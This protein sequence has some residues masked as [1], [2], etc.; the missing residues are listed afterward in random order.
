MRQIEL[1]NGCRCS[2]PSV[3]PKD[4]KRATT[5]VKKEWRIQYYFYDPVRSPRGKLFVIKAGINECK[6][7]SER[8]EMIY[9]MLEELVHL[10][11]EGYNPHLRRPDDDRET[12]GTWLNA[13]KK[14]SES[15][16]L[17]KSTQSDLKSALK[18]INAAASHLGYQ[19][20]F[21]ADIRAKHIRSILKAAATNQGVFSGHKFNKYRSYLMILFNEMIDQ[22]ITEDN[23]VNSI[24]KADTIQKIRKTLSKEQRAQI[25]GL[26]KSTNYNFRR[27]MQIFFHSG[28]R[29]KEMLALKWSDVDLTKQMFIVT[30]LKGK[31]SGEQMRAIKNIALPF[32]QELAAIDN[33][34]ENY[35]FSRGL[36][37]G[38]Q[39]IRREQITRRWKDHVKKKMGITP[40]FYSLKHSNLDEIAE[41]AGIDTSAFA[42]GHKS[43]VVTM[44]FYATGEKMRE[45]ESVKKVGNEF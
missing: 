29:I 18:G 45:L 40:D 19:N 22:E 39:M 3:Y 15:L 37:P 31:K 33:S 16:T 44:K 24:R 38:P 25:D 28:S 11:K 32:W 17:A 8:R 12:I 35:V 14:A 5:S 26:L 9:P 23:P 36:V 1:P 10:L 30:V 43:K 13:C 4:W 2:R 27:F 6:K 34:P 20:Y 42:G 41:I 21:L 7:A